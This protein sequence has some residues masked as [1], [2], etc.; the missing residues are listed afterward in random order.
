LRAAERSVLASL[1]ARLDQSW[2]CSDILIVNVVIL[3]Q[4]Q[5]RQSLQHHQRAFRLEETEAALLLLLALALLLAAALALLAALLLL[6]LAA[7]LAVGLAGVLAAAVT[8]RR[9]AGHFILSAPILF[10]GWEGLQWCN[11]S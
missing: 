8:T 3:L 10:G 1:L 6:L 5:L 4:G 7:R 11:Q 2:A 9:V